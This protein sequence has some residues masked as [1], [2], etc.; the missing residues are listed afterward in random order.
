MSIIR[1]E[2]KLFG[3][4]VGVGGTELDILR[5]LIDGTEENSGYWGQKLTFKKI[6]TL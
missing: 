1:I 6:K 5:E 2:E 4:E 3:M